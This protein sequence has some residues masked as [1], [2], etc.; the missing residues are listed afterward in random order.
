MV[1]SEHCDP[2]VILMCFELTT[3]LEGWPYYFEYNVRKI[4]KRDKE[5]NYDLINHT[6]YCKLD[7]DL[8]VFTEACIGILDLRSI[9]QRVQQLCFKV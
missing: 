4:D 2:E 5:K 6:L 7:I 9:V 1:Q 3:T 8:H